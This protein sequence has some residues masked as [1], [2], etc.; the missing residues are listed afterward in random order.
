MQ[1]GNLPLHGAAQYTKSEAVIKALLDAYPDAAKE[2]DVRCGRW[3]R[4]FLPSSLSLPT[5]LLPCAGWEAA[6][7]K[8]RYAPE[9]EGSKGALTAYP[10]HAI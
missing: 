10:G 4:V 6:G 5:C 8:G 7:S 3:R 9:S 1:H 2:T